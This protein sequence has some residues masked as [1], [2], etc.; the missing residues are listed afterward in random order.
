M[1]LKSLVS[2]KTL[3]TFFT[4][5][6]ELFATK[7]ELSEGL[8]LKADEGHNHDGQYY[9]E[10]EVDNKLDAKSDKTHNHDDV[11]YTESEIN[12][13]LSGKSDTGHTHDDRYLT[14]EETTNAIT[15]AKNTLQ[16]N[17]DNKADKNHGNHVPT[18]QT[19]DNKIFLRNDNTWA[20]ITPENIGA[21]TLADLNT[22]ESNV[23]TQLGVQFNEVIQPAL[24]LKQDKSSALQLGETSSTAYRGDRGAVAYTHSQVTHAPSDAQK[25]SDITKAEIE[26]KLTGEIESHSH[27]GQYYSETEI[28]T[29]LAAISNAAYT[30]EQIDEQLALRDRMHTSLYPTGTA[31]PANADLNTINYI[32]VGCYYCGAN[33]T[34]A[35]LVNC[36]TNIAFMMEVISPLSTSY[37][38]EETR[39]W[40]YRLRRLTIHNTGEQYLQLVSS[41]A[42]A[43]EFTYGT[44]SKVALK[45]EIDSAIASHA[46]NNLYYSKSEVDTKL[47]NVADANRLYYKGNVGSTAV[48]FPLANFV[49][50]SSSNYGNIMLS[51]RMGRWEN[52]GAANFDIMLVNRSNNKDGNTITATVTAQGEVAT[53]LGVA[54]IVIYKQEDLSHKAYIKATGYVIWDL[55]YKENQHSIVYDGTSSTDVP[56]GE[57]IWSLSTANKSILSPAG[58]LSQ[59]GTPSQNSDLTTKSY[60]DGRISNHSHSKPQPGNYFVDGY[61][62][63]TS[64]GVMEVGK[65][66]DWHNTNDETIDYSVRVQC[67][68][69]N[70]NTVYLPQKTGRLA[71]LEDCGTYLNRNNDLNTTESNKVYKMQFAQ[72]NGN[73]D[74]MPDTSWWS[75]IRLQHGGYD[76]GYW[77]DIAVSFSGEMKV[78]YNQNGTF[79][80]WRQVMFTDNIWV[81]TQAEY[82]AIATKNSNTLYLIKE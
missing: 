65:Y 63:M 36:P 50:D 23:S 22:T 15:T 58:A 2:I 29:K 61:A 71:V 6:T 24:D 10:S 60:V 11:Y 75:L 12:T 44:W 35:T 51:G 78:R 28:D 72:V 1:N 59:T 31:I 77:Q 32:K 48:Y 79:G 80:P 82:D 40:V 74:L 8:T 30:K 66:Q 27:N 47:T 49:V 34:V 26:A 7:E 20:E 46:H 64:D 19:A 21:A 57:L 17:I 41:G 76:A 73:A 13:K 3:Q 69:S 62:G 33:A 56:A 25:N 14:E 18:I 42:T 16:A 45:S 54:D 67:D 81:G 55:E 38:D 53:A 39:T 52:I 4:K 37:D 5:L 43:G 9:T 68:S 70:G